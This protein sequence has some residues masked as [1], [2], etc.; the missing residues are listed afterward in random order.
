MH[1]LF[2][3]AVVSVVLTALLTVVL[4]AADRP[5]FRGRNGSGVAATSA[6]PVKFSSTKNVVWKSPLPAG[7]SS[8]VLADRHIFLT[9]G[10]ED[11][12]LTIAIDRK[13]GKVLWRQAVHP[14]RSE[15][16]HQLNSPASS[17]PATD[18]TNVYAFCFLQ[19][20]AH[21]RAKIDSL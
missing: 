18:G 1:V 17:T 15:R 11:D 2:F 19:R 20:Q 7:K 12:L 21:R 14:G 5:G 3:R 6:L 9:A 10:Q 16:L 13:T 4:T 8:S